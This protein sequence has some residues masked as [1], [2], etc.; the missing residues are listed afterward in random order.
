M[1]LDEIFAALVKDGRVELKEG[2]VHAKTLKQH[3][4]E[5]VGE[6]AR[7]PGGVALLE[8][9]TIRKRLG[10]EASEWLSSLQ[11]LPYIESTNKHLME[12]AESGSVDGIVLIAEV[13]TGG[14]GRRGRAWISPFGRNIAMSMGMKLVCHPADL[15]AVS[16]VIGLAVADVLRSVG[17][18][19]VTLKWPNDVL[20]EGRKVSGIL[21]EL[22]NRSDSMEMV[23]GVGINVG[24]KEFL[25][26]G[27]EQEV[28]AVTEQIR[29]LS[30]SELAGK[31]INSV[32][33]YCREFEE[34]GFGVFHDRW[35]ALHAHQDQQVM[36]TSGSAVV[37]GVCRGISRSGALL[38]DNGTEVIE[39]I[40][41][42]ITVRRA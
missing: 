38:V 41:G 24:A 12:I 13:Q 22:T 5:V 27:I 31:V 7:L 33:G 28:A 42:E 26:A 34:H 29:D 3:G 40:G 1:T 15:V 18:R 14:R 25:M 8:A 19:S 4:L 35:M 11:L 20:I 39:L 30:R 16:L 6:E 9:G 17:V 21:I 23:I 2:S 37:H 32:H 36:V 10:R